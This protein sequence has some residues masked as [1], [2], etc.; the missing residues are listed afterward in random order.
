MLDPNATRMQPLSPQSVPVI[1]DDP[2]VAL[3]VGDDHDEDAVVSVLVAAWL[4]LLRWFQPGIK[5]DIVIV[6]YSSSDIL[7]INY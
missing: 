3:R 7:L 4:W 1:L 5:N 6:K 2:V